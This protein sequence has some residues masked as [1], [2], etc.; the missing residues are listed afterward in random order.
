M[1][2]GEQENLSSSYPQV[3]RGTRGAE[4]KVRGTCLACLLKVIPFRL[5]LPTRGGM[6]F[7]PLLHIREEFEGL[8]GNYIIL[9]EEQ[10]NEPLLLYRVHIMFCHRRRDRG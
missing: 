10:R 5:S 9:M 7:L 2:S 4:R 1:G 3:R 8:Q 6:Y